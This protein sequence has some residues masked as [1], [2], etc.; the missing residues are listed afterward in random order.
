MESN[1]IS[2]WWASARLSILIICFTILNTLVAGPIYPPFVSWRRHY[3]HALIIIP[4]EVTRAT[5][6]L[7][8][9]QVVLPARSFSIV[10]TLWITRIV[11]SIG[12]NRR[13]RRRRRWN[14]WLICTLRVCFVWHGCTATFFGI[15]AKFPSL[16]LSSTWRLSVTILYTSTII[17]VPVN[18]VL[19]RVH[20][21]YW[22]W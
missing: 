7:G 8:F 14:E 4:I 15:V 11:T 19:A 9:V 3:T 21:C 1:P 5:G 22:L 6:L 16:N 17:D 10:N 2:W 12:R 13:K 18:I 20:D